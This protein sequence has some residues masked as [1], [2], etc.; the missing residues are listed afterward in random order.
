MAGIYRVARAEA[1]LEQL[2]Q[3]A[4]E[5]FFRLLRRRRPQRRRAAPADP[6]GAAAAQA[7]REALQL[8]ERA[9]TGAF[10]R[11]SD[12]NKR[13]LLDRFARLLRESGASPQRINS[14]KGN[15]D[16]WLRTPPAA[17]HGSSAG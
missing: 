5:S 14:M 13:R 7:R 11:Q 3:R 6:H 15:F 12:A 16:E 9:K 17:R 1:E 8:Y 4:D 2:L 10:T